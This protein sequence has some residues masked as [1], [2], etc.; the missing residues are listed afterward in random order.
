M[1][2]KIDNPLDSNPY[3]LL[4]KGGLA[5]AKEW[6]SSGDEMQK[7]TGAELVLNYYTERYNVLNDDAKKY[8]GINANELEKMAVDILVEQGHSKLVKDSLLKKYEY[9]PSTTKKYRQNPNTK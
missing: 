7:C 9:S 8:V 4:L 3:I 2:N 1:E 5:H 6:M